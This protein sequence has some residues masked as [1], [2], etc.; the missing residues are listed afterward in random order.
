M[1]KPRI[2]LPGA[3][4]HVTARVNNREMLL[5]PERVKH[6][7]ETVLHKAK[8]KYSFSIEN[9][10]IMNNHIHLIIRP[11][12]EESLSRI[13]QWILSVF[14]LVYNRKTGRSGHFWGE[15]FFS[16]ILNSLQQY[17]NAYEY[18]SYNP[19]VAGLADDPAS[20]RFGGI[21]HRKK[22]WTF[23][24]DSEFPLYEESD[25]APLVSLK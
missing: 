17:L 5:E 23:L 21:F 16:A 15:R 3:R 4:Y 7:F 18:I 24:L 2:L 19:V 1:R 22:R 8:K 20:W 12:G 25:Q 9:F 14:A 10:T 13:M 6:L 11:Q